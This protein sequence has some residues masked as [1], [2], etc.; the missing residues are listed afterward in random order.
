MDDEERFRHVNI[1]ARRK[2]VL[3]GEPLLYLALVL[4]FIDHV[5]L[6]SVVLVLFM[7]TFVALFNPQP[8]PRTWRVVFWYSV[9]CFYLRLLMR[10]KY[11]ACSSGRARR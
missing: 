5:D 3:S 4:N 1:F 9:T 11:S 10:S 2:I 6:M 7:I 8:T